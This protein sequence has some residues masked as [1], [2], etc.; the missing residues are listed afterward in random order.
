MAVYRG[1][2]ILA[3]KPL[4]EDPSCGVSCRSGSGREVNVKRVSDSCVCDKGVGRFLQD[5]LWRGYYTRDLCPNPSHPSEM[6]PQ[7]ES[8]INKI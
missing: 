5:D 1:K 7:H 6:N 2:V 8:C 3:G 4:W